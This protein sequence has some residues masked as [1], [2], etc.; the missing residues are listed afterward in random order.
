M[1]ILIKRA[2][3]IEDKTFTI[4]VVSLLVNYITANPINQ[5]AMMELVQK[6]V[7][8][9]ALAL[10]D[11]E[12]LFYLEVFLYNALCN[13]QEDYLNEFFAKH[14]IFKQVFTKVLNDIPQYS[15]EKYVG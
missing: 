13:Q 10:E 1:E 5:V 3:E 9:V 15:D 14:N 6:N 8:V 7:S 2:C 4:Q 11:N 12:C